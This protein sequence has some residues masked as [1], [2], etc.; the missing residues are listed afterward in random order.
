MVLTI[1]NRRWGRVEDPIPFRV[2][3]PCAGIILPNVLRPKGKFGFPFGDYRCFRLMGGERVVRAA[4]R[5]APK[6]SLGEAPQRLHEMITAPPAAAI[7]E[8]PAKMPGIPRR[9]IWR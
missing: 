5:V 6:A 2:T 7:Q 3:K 9:R 8:H 4:G 1:W